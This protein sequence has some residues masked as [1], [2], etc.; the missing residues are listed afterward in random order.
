VIPELIDFLRF[1]GIPTEGRGC[2]KGSIW[3]LDREGSAITQ[4]T[5]LGRP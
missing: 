2:E 4:A 3:Q 5:Y 1:K